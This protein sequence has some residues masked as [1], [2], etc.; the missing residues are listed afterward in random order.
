M[1]ECLVRGDVPAFVGRV[2]RVWEDH[3]VA[4]SIGQSRELRPFKAVLCGAMAPMWIYEDWGL[5]LEFRWDVKVE[6]Y[7]CG[8]G[9]EVFNLD[10]RAGCT[11]CWRW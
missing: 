3:D 10:E 9:A 11:E 8:I 7:V 6:A 1:G 4:M 5:G 2:W